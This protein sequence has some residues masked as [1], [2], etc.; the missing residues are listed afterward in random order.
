MNVLA[1]LP[2]LQPGA[3]SR[4]LGAR[5]PGQGPTVSAGA[6]LPAMGVAE[7]LLSGDHG[8][9]RLR[10]AHPVTAHRQAL[11]AEEA[12]QRGTAPRLHTRDTKTGVLARPFMKQGELIPDDIMTPLTLQEL[13][14]LAQYSWLLCG[15]PRTLPQAEALERAYQTH[16]VLHLNVPFEAIMQRLSARWVHPAGGR[17]YN[18]EFNPPKV[19]GVDDLTGE[20]LIKHEDDR[21]EILIKRLKAYEDQTKPVLEYYQE[22]GVLETFPGTET[23]KLWPYIHACLQTKVPHAHWTHWFFHEEKCW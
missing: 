19:V 11:G 16:L 12:L 6:G 14:N 17:V 21:P 18:L 8:L 23:N 3:R 13:K 10:Q 20:P 15:F 22:K 5:R 2:S 9:P 7:Q 1:A 4:E